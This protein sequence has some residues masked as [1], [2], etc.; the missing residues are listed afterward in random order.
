MTGRSAAASG[1][2]HVLWGMPASLYTAKARAFL[3]KRRIPFEERVPGDPRFLGEVVPAVGRWI[4][5][6][7]QC[8]DG[9]LVQDGALIVDHVD[10]IA[11]Q[12]PRAL[13]PDPALAALAR[14]LEFFGGEGLL[15]PAMHYRWNF[16]ADNL[17]FLRTDFGASLAPGAAPAQAAAVFERSSTR[18]RKAT[19][20]FGVDPHSIPTIERAFAELLALLE[21]HFERVPYLLGPAPTVADYGLYAPLGP[22]LGR[23]P[24]PSM[25]LKRTAPR[26][27]RWLER[28]AAP[29]DDA[30]E[31]AHRTI[32]WLDAD[33]PGD[34]FEALLRYVADEFLPEVRAQVAFADDWLA[35]RPGIAA[36]TN[37]LERP[38]ERAIGRTG[39]DWRGLR[40]EVAVMPYRLFLLQ[41]FQDAAAAVEPAA[42]AP[43]HALLARTGLAPLLGL[44]CRRRVERH[45][46]LEAWGP[47]PD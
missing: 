37:G 18:M 1:P 4:I 15:R 8:P 41:R 23:D 29:D 27:W 30:G 20:A 43:L 26:T 12:G 5:P 35:A 33:A 14:L 47:P 11:T 46:H 22:H 2:P 6:V 9:T 28:M 19:R 7:L 17:D 44:R 3:R 13:P 39:V 16:D 10:R 25:L 38:G 32:G 42:A 45:G 40:I 21:R 34:T 24:H 36:G 31:Y